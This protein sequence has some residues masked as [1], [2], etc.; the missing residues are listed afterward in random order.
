MTPRRFQ[1]KI[2]SFLRKLVVN[3]Y[4]CNQLVF[5]IKADTGMIFFRTFPKNDNDLLLRLA[6]I[7]NCSRGEISSTS[8]EVIVVL[9]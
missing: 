4:F 2:T 7:N 1:T 8:I 6:S 9:L 3:S 5:A